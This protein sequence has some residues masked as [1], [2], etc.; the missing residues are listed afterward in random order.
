MRL[1]FNLKKLLVNSDK[2]RTFRQKHEYAR[3]Y[4]QTVRKRYR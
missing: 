2:R 1:D 4:I 3:E